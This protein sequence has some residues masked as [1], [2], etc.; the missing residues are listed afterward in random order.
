MLPVRD[1]PEPPLV[2]VGQ[3]DQG[4]V[5][6]GQ[7]GGPVIGLGQAHPGQQ[8]A[9]RQLPGAHPGRQHDLDPRRDAGG[10]DDLLER[11]Q[12]DHDGRAAPSSR[13][14]AASPAGSSPATRSPSRWEQLIPAACMNVARPSRLR[15]VG[16]PGRAQPAG[17]QPR[18]PAPAVE[19]ADQ[20]VRDVPAARIGAAADQPVPGAPG[21][22]QQPGVVAGQHRH[23]CA[24]GRRAP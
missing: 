14:A 5:H 2:I 8:G 1:H 17:V 16:Q 13:T 4:L 24:A 20:R 9:D 3:A 12:R 18:Q 21:R 10:V 6:A 11:R 15:A 7:V 19:R 22:R 23:R